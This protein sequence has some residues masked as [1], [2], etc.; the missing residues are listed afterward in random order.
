MEKSLSLTRLFTN[1][2]L[3]DRFGL[4]EKAGFTHVELDDWTD[5][6]ITRVGEMLEKHDLKLAAFLG[7]DHDLSKTETHKDF[8]EHLSQSIA[9]AKVFACDKL[10]VESNIGGGFATNAGDTTMIARDDLLNAALA[11]RILM[12]AAQRAQKAGVTLL[13]KP[14]SASPTFMATLRLTGNVVA[15]VNS[16]AVRL[17]LDA[18]ELWKCRNQPE[19]AQVM[20]RIHKFVEHI[21]IGENA[22]RNTWN[23]ELIWF[24]KHVTRFYELNCCLGLLY[25]A[26]A[27]DSYILTPFREL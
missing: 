25:P 11:S 22:D 13:L 5:L 1:A 17:L 24:T 6:D 20:R 4:A 3:Y 7:A 15:A 10:I 16:H 2:D 26:T 9:I 12:A 18:T 14:P 27:E 23:D 21:H 19:A 8:S